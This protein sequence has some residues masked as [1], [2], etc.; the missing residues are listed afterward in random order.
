M[1]SKTLAQTLRL[2]PTRL[3][4]GLRQVRDLISDLL[5]IPALPDTGGMDLADP[6]HEAGRVNTENREQS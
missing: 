2:L 1:S 4:S 5:E 3:S 6:M